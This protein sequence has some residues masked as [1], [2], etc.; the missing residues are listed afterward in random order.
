MIFLKTVK[1][2]YILYM[3]FKRAFMEFYFM[4]YDYIQT[5]VQLCVVKEFSF[6]MMRQAGLRSLYSLL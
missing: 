2:N 4:M 5:T 1:I 6:F 3:S